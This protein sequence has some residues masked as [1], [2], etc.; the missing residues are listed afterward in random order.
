MKRNNWTDNP[1][2]YVSIIDGKKFNVVL[3]PFSTHKEALDMVEP[4]RNE[5]NK[6]DPK[7]HFYGWGTVKMAN[8]YKGG[9]L[10]EKFNI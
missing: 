5:G 2:Y 8:G 10:N 6:L 4:A 1:C 9:L 3:G 7:S